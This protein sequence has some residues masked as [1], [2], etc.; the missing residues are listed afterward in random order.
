MVR[1]RPTIAYAALV[2]E[3]PTRV[4][5]STIQRLLRKLKIRKW[6]SRKRIVLTEE[7]AKE[8]LKMARFWTNRHHPEPLQALRQVSW[9]FGKP[10]SLLLSLLLSLKY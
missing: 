2:H 8:R 7:T 1:R 10:F 3:P 9:Q 4:S 6:V 5:R